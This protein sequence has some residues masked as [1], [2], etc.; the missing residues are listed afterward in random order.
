MTKP[1]AD[2]EEGS[3]ARSARQ[4]VASLCT[5]TLCYRP[6]KKKCPTCDELD[7]PRTRYCGIACFK[8]CW[9]DH[10]L[11]HK[12]A[13]A[14]RDQ[15]QQQQQQQQESEHPADTDDDASDSDASVD[16][17]ASVSEAQPAEG[18]AGQIDDDGSAGGWFEAKPT[19]ELT[20]DDPAAQALVDG[21]NSGTIEAKSAE[22]G[23]KVD[24][25]LEAHTTAIDSEDSGDVEDHVTMNSDN[26]EAKPAESI[27]SKDAGP[28]ATEV[29]SIDASA[30][31]SKPGGVRI[32]GATGSAAAAINGVYEP[33]KGA[34][35]KVGNDDVRLEY[36]AARKQWQVKSTVEGMITKAVRGLCTVPVKCSP[37]ECPSGQWKA[38]VDGKLANQPAIA[39]SV[40]SKDDVEAY[41]SELRNLENDVCSVRI[42]GAAGV[43]ELYING[44]YVPTDEKCSDMPVY[45]KADDSD[46][47]LEYRNG[48][49]PS[50]QVKG[51]ETKGKDLFMAYCPVDTNCLPQKCP[52]HRW[53]VYDG[54]ENV[55]QPSIAITVVSK[56]ELGAY[57][58]EME[59]EAA[60]EVKGS[61]AVRIAG[62]K[63]LS[64]PI[65][66]GIYEATDDTSFN[67][68]V[69]RKMGDGD[70]W[71]EYYGPSRSWQVKKGVVDRGKDCYVAYCPVGAKCLP[72]M[73]PVRDWF[74][75]DGTGMVL[76]PSIAITVVSKKEVEAY[77]T[78]MR[79][80]AA[81]VMKGNQAVRITGVTGTNIA[82]NG[83]YVPTAEMFNNVT[84]YAKLGDENKFLEYWAPSK[85]WHVKEAINKGTEIRN[86]ECSVVKSK[87][88]PEGCPVGQWRVAD[89]GAIVS[90]PA[91]TISAVS[92]E[93]EVAYRVDLEKEA[94]RVVKGR[95][96]VR[97]DGASGM[98]AALIN[99][100]YEITD[101]M[102][103]KVS[104]Y[105]K[106]GDD[107]MWMEYHS[108]AKQ[109]QIK[110][111]ADTKG[112]D[113]CM[114]MCD[115]SIKCLPQDCP[116]GRWKVFVD[117][118]SSRIQ[119]D[120]TISVV[121]DEE[122][123]A[124]RLKMEQ[125]TARELK[126]SQAVRIIGAIGMTAFGINGIYK[127]T[128]EMSDNVTV[129]RK[130]GGEDI[131]LEYF[132]FSRAWRF[133]TINAEGLQTTWARFTVPVPV[134]CLP[135]ECLAGQCEVLRANG[136]VLQPTV[137]I[138]MATEEEVEAYRADVER[139]AARV[140]KGNQAVRIDGVKGI[141]AVA[142]N[143]VYQPDKIEMSD[144]VSI[145]Y[146]LGDDLALIAYYSLTK[147]WQIKS[148]ADAKCTSSMNAYCVAPVKVNLHS[149]DTYHMPLLKSVPTLTSPSIINSYPY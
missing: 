28:R 38:A 11:L 18:P 10:S 103:G 69:Y 20:K 15:Q 124:Y 47:W 75:Y 105:A 21:E 102:S 58:L 42:D 91:I 59:H 29:A 43:N 64:A 97:I 24:Q 4:L 116:A 104:V 145:Y 95:H 34:Y 63:G 3:E 100:V 16:R 62:V 123:E 84:V 115:I 71:L 23:P 146:K 112:L 99:G 141:N 120:V 61:Q 86:A 81:R 2:E 26:S 122:V 83:V 19:A 17:D 27:K 118:N 147:Q 31:A 60:R 68:T 45:Q 133:T 137:T 90:Q 143:G 148:G 73:C 40:V 37:N 30:A 6:G 89:D 107:D 130:V 54:A 67:V 44:V 132:A 52:L 65:I 36:Y 127:P 35:R 109:W 41:R 66:N 57:R 48:A 92:K 51:A 85:Q 119:R 94:A 33:M 142:I 80:E 110:H 78:D 12:Q 128:D 136:I 96:A 101:E 129:Y 134:K 125:E 1:L 121:S 138:T 70:M 72:E 25:S 82:I 14:Y 144:N 8:I 76:Q 56:N 22:A 108:R 9:S 50:W 53:H 87:C 117:D 98:K 93:E 79:R 140:V 114:A 149:L 126:G 106:I 77:R 7:L 88:L 46:T 39:V 135:Q 32:A 139:E 5:N 49:K 13:E 74:V 113:C 131:W 55:L 111:G